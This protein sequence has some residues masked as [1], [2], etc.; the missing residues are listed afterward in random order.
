MDEAEGDFTENDMVSINRQ[1]DKSVVEGNLND[2]VTKV[3]I[4][5][6]RSR[7]YVMLKKFP[8]LL[9]VLRFSK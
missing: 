1:V 8:S 6:S 7:V 9:D 5:C 4:F 3:S 2:A